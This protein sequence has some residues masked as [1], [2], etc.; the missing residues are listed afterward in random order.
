VYHLPA[1]GETAMQA[2]SHSLAVAHA[3]AKAPG[4]PLHEG[5]APTVLVVDDQRDI[6]EA[7]RLLLK[8]EGYRVETA[9]SPQGALDA[10]RGSSF[11]AAILDLNYARDTP[12]GQEGLQLLADIRALAPELPVLAMTAWGSIPLA[13]EAMRQGAADFVTKPWDSAHLLTTLRR[14][15]DR[16]ESGLCQSPAQLGRRELS[17]ARAVQQRLFPRRAPRLTTLTCAAACEES[18]PVGGD[19]YDFLALGPG[20]LGLVVGDVAGKGVPAA[21]VMAHL[22]ATLRGLAPLMRDDLA[23]TTRRINRLLLET[24]ETS[25]YATAFLATYEE[26]RRL[27]RYVG[28]GHPPP[29]VRRPDGTLTWLEPSAPI[30]G[31]LESFEPIVE[32][33]V[34]GEGTDLIA[35]SDGLIET[36]GVD[37]RELGLEGLAAFASR[38]LSRD[39]AAVLAALMAERRAFAA[40]TERDDVTVLVARG[41]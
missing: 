10:L 39:P 37:G 5:R 26:E 31:L 18:G 29:L 13:V 14:C 41:R 19:F 36:R 11:G 40:G 32:Q 25:S 21:I 34:I 4:R 30:L 38:G 23:E 27:L 17:V 22:S 16:S 12:S 28:C 15:L 35:Y 20:R 24:T 8:P 3:V 6:L 1:L 33:V 7:F 2:A 9:Q